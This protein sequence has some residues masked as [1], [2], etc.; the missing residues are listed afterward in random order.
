MKDFFKKKIESAL[1][2][3]DTVTIQESS[4]KLYELCQLETNYLK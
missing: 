1:K 3:T 4:N 2:E